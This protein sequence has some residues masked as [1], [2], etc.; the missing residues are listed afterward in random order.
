MLNC[1]HKVSKGATLK[2]K[3]ET[4]PNCQTTL[5]HQFNMLTSQMKK[6]E[7]SENR[8]NEAAIRV[9]EL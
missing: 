2:S 7:I 1:A 9:G 6:T 8:E 3:Q 5:E 4:G